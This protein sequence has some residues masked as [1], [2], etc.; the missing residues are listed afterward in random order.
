MHAFAEKRHRREAASDL[1]RPSSAGASV[2]GQTFKAALPP[3]IRGVLESRGQP[4]ESGVREEMESHFRFDFSKV[5]IHHNDQAR[6]A[7]KS[8]GARAFSFQNHVVFDSAQYSP[9]TSDGKR[10]LAHE[11]AHVLQ[12]TTASASEQA[13]SVGFLHDSFEVEAS[14]ASA[15]L[16][17]QRHPMISQAAGSILRMEPDPR[18]AEYLSRLDELA[19][20]Y[21]ALVSLSQSFRSPDSIGR[22]VGVILD[23]LEGLDLSNIDNRQPVIARTVQRFS[24]AVADELSYQ[25][26]PT[27][28]LP[29]N[30]DPHGDP[31]YVDNITAGYYN[32]LT[33]EFVLT[34]ADGTPVHLSFADVLQDISRTPSTGPG[35][36]V[37]VYVY[38]R[39]RRT[40]RIVPN[41]YNSTTTPNITYVAQQ[42][43]AAQRQAEANVISATAMGAPGIIVSWSAAGRPIMIRIP[44]LS[45]VRGSITPALNV[46]EG[47]VSAGEGLV[48]GGITIPTTRTPPLGTP[49]G[50]VVYTGPVQ[51]PQ[52][53]FEPPPVSTGAS[54]RI[55]TTRMPRQ[56]FPPPSFGI[57]QARVAGPTPPLRDVVAGRGRLT[58]RQIEQAIAQSR[59]RTISLYTN[60]TQRPQP[61]VELYLARE[62]SL[63]QAA[64]E[65]GQVYEVQI[66]DVLFYRLEEIGGWFP[67]SLSMRG[68]TGTE[69]RVP[70]SISWI[71]IRFLVE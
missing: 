25:I 11:L 13:P 12:S 4:L 50:N 10:L 9:A 21:A 20:D 6:A 48:S 46:R 24:Q 30:V 27:E 68:A 66:P 69:V 44:S 18:L 36:S 57:G 29:P 51:R 14:Q 40:G 2:S 28:P 32:I 19:R 3:P 45:R 71:F 31:N 62:R 56:E 70:D 53:T 52:V 47:M 37:S 49:E 59:G 54:M 64:R 41:V 7:A 38:A 1:T 34:H 22:L 5:Q 35:I 17:A 23:R 16:G 26:S 8:L 39:D 61:G 43:R 42:I 65:G 58:V 33:G 60:Q 63:A 15:S 55:P 67:G